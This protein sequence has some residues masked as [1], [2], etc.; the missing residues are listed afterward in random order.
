MFKDRQ[1]AA[2]KL[3]A[4]IKKRYPRIDNG[5]VLALPRGG[6]VI[7]AE[8]AKKLNLPLDIIATRKI[9][10]PYNPEYA[11]AAVSE[12]EIIM[13]SHDKPDLEYLKAEVEKERQEIQR[14]LREYRQG[15]KQLNLIDKTVILI[16]DGIATGLTMEVAIRETRFQKPAKIILAVPV[17]PPETIERLKN[18]VDDNIVLNIEGL[19]FA[20]SQFY[21][22]FPQ[23]TDEEVKDL[24]AKFKSPPARGLIVE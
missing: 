6:V 13:S 17:A 1:D 21:E 24:L 2:Q 16:D 11:V 22:N 19:F 8:V 9:G 18:I 14:R 4:K 3:A 20:I 12:N 5:I 23:T 15:Q 10:A 7:G